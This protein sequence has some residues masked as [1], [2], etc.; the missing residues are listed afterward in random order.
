M[1]DNPGTVTGGCMCSAVRYEATGEPLEIG[2]C[3]C[4]SCR[5]HTGAPVVTWVMFE[6]NKVRFTGR[7]RSIYNSSPGV[8]RA[9]CGQ[10]GTPL[11]GEGDHEG[12]VIIGFHISTFDNP[13]A[14]VPDK[15]WYHNERIEWF[16]VADN[17]PRYWED[18]EGERLYR[19]GPATEG[20]QA[21]T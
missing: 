6:A 18:D 19:H 14:F 17:L 11:T 8:K 1:D 5:R 9:F 20:P 15:H 4:H 13:E 12:Q 3:H 16:D 21:D 7:E 10:C 2:Y